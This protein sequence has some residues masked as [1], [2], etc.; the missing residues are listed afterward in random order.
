MTIQKLGMPK[1]GLSMKEGKVLDWLVDEGPMIDQGTPVAEVETE[2][3]SGEVEAPAAGVLRRQ[4]A[5]AGKVYPV[6]ALLGVIAD[7]DDS[8]ADIDTFVEEFI[9][10]FVPEEA[11]AEAAGPQPETI[12]VGGRKLRYLMLGDDQDSVPAVLLHGYGGDLN[13][14]LFNQEALAGG[15]RVYALDL[16]GHGG[17]DKNVGAGD[18]ASLAETFS[19]FLDAVGVERAH[20]VGHS[21]GGA[22]ASRLAL[23]R[24][25]RVASLT[26]IAGAGL[27]EQISREYI[28]GFLAA[29]RRRAMRQV[30]QLLFAD[31]DQVSRQLVDD[32]L[33]YKRLDGV[34]EALR[35]LAGQ[36]FPDGRQ[37][38]VLAGELAAA[39]VPVLV[40]WGAQ[41]QVIPSEHANALGDRARVEVL[42]ATGHSPHMERAGEVNRLLPRFWDET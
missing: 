6:G 10:S 22:V 20:L 8:D 34:D 25:D 40:I 41:D 4:V 36:L 35:T 28:E 39:D 21:L 11:A 42:D 17:S 5:E 9:A 23:D 26:L 29:D 12:E 30:L 19:G 37:Q 3:I 31:P 7:A 33:K 14:W 13:N 15:R 1:W 38:A 24:P 18:L 16:P 2:K 27:G 32:V